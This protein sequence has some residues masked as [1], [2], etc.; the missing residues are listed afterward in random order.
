MK[1]P[2][3][4]FD[5]YTLNAR[6]APYFIPWLPALL[7]FLAWYPLEEGGWDTIA[8]LVIAVGLI[9][10]MGQLG[11]DAGRSKQVTLSEKWGG[12]PTTLLLRY[13][14]SWIER[15]TLDRYKNKLRELCPGV[16]SPSEQDE[17]QNPA[18]SDESYVAWVRYL[19][20]T[21]RDAS[22]FPLVLAEN[23]N[24]G[25]RRNL[26]ALKPYGIGLSLLGL[27]ASGIAVLM[28]ASNRDAPNPVA[29]LCV[30]ISSG[31][32]YLWVFRISQSWV[33]TVGNAYAE[34]L[35]E[36]CDQL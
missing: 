24:F 7:S 32:L 9:G 10:L 17:E 11:R 14:T 27:A 35:L 16:H 18:K 31:L 13:R 3:T 21:T 22:R 34:R 29:I 15:S 6:I 20:A 30:V 23:I 8:A 33:R 28:D 2:F 25:F 1:V 26:W 5:R 4:E 36:C 19:R 12:M